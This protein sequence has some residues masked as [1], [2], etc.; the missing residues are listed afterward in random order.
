MLFK[1]IKEI[2]IR[3]LKFNINKK[4]VISSFKDVIKY[5]QSSMGN[6]KIELFKIIFL[7]SNNIILKDEI[8]QRG[9]TNVIMVYPREIVKKAVLVDA[10]AV[11]IA[12]N[13]P[14]GKCKP[15]KSDIVITKNIIT[16]LNIFNIVLH[17]HVIITNQRY[18]SFK[19]HGMLTN[20]V[21]LNL[22][23]YRQKGY[24][25]SQ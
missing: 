24:Q 7:D 20:D 10:T 13:H 5:L 9:S 23:N 18:F 17:D 19:E 15:S 3:S 16:A 2:S 25:K 1:L 6:E 12:H 4:N 8:M 11:I 22:L 14:S 21:P